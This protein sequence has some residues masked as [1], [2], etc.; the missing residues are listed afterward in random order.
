MYSASTTGITHSTKREATTLQVE[1]MRLDDW[2]TSNYSSFQLMAFLYH[3]I[4][5]G[6]SI[7]LEAAHAFTRLRMSR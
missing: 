1:A 2:S 7:S 4:L 6:E 5:V 3:H